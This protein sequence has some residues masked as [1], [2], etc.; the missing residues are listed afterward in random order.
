MLQLAQLRR[1]KIRLAASDSEVAA[2]KIR[3]A[4]REAIKKRMGG[5]LLE[6]WSGPAGRPSPT[7]SGATGLHG[8]MIRL[9]PGVRQRTLLSVEAMEAMHPHVF[10]RPT[11][12]NVG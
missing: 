5:V 10:L 1:K 3:Q 12:A 11:L 7:E 2:D 8:A 9:R 6:E 4:S